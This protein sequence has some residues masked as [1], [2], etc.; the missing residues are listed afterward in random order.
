MPDTP[1]SRSVVLW[2]QVSGLATV[3]GA[4][5]LTWIAYNL[6]LPQLLNQMGF[7]SELVSALLIVESLLAMVLEPTFGLLSDRMQRWLGSRFPFIVI[8][9]VLSSILFLCLPAVAF[10]G[11]SISALRWLLPTVAIAWSL[12]MT[13]FRSPALALLG[14]YSPAGQLPR[15]ASVLTLVGAVI[16]AIVPQVNEFIL[17]LGAAPTFAV[18]SIVLLLAATLLRVMDRQIPPPLPQEPPPPISMAPLVIIFAVGVATSIGFGLVKPLLTLREV[19]GIFSIA[20]I[21]L[22]IPAGLWAVKLGNRRAM[23]GGIVAMILLLGIL[24]LIPNSTVAVATAV[25]LSGAF[26]LVVNGTLP[27]ALT[28]F[29]SSRAGLGVG[30]YLGGTALAG[31]LSKALQLSAQPPFVVACIVAIALTS[32]ASCIS[33]CTPKVTPRPIA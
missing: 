25:L 28:M 27:L 13:V 18:G 10:F 30:I 32:A 29:P 31:S 7:P 8:G 23:I 33:F 11:V 20:N 16:S 24:S 19:A 14:R 15:A 21:F 12:A 5:S 1:K 4:I 9:V 3:Q 6:Y 17:K 22:V 2:M 26:S